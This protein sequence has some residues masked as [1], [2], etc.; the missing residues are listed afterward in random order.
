M[1]K[2]K[3]WNVSKKECS[4][5]LDDSM[6]EILNDHD[7]TELTIQEM[8]SLL[9]EYSKFPTLIKNSSRKTMIQYIN[10]IYGGLESYLNKSKKSF[11]IIIND[12]QKYVRVK[13]LERNYVNDGWVLL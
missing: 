1:G 12:K 13:E 11:E 9:Q 4:K 2:K 6:V 3:Q 7:T 5:I 8:Q 10:E